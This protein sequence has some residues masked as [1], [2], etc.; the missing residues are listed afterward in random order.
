V[1]IE[2]KALGGVPQ[3]SRARSTRLTARRV[4]WPRRGLPV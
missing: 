1:S 2:R 4:W 3:A